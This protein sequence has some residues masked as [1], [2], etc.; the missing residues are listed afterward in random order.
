M[1]LSVPVSVRPWVTYASAFVAL[2]SASYYATTWFWHKKIHSVKKRAN[3]QL[4]LP[5]STPL[6]I[7]ISKE[8]KYRIRDVVLPYIDQIK[9]GSIHHPAVVDYITEKDV[10]KYL[11]EPNETFC[12]TEHAQAL[13]KNP[14][15]ESLFRKMVFDDKNS[16]LANHHLFLNHCPYPDILQHFNEIMSWIIDW[17]LLAT[18]NNEG[19]IKLIEMNLDKLDDWSNLSANP[20]AIDILK[21]NQ[22]KINWFTICFNKS[23]GDLLLQNQKMIPESFTCWKIISKHQSNLNLLK[24]NLDWVNWI[25]LSLN[26]SAIPL[27][28]EY[29]DKIKWKH[30]SSL[31]EAIHLIKNNLDKINWS[32]LSSNSAA[33]ELLKQHPD[34]IDWDNFCLNESKIAVEM[35]MENPD[36]IN[37]KTIVL[38]KS[39]PVEFLSQHIDKVWRFLN[40]GILQNPNLAN[41]IFVPNEQV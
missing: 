2:A 19:I 40:F 4:P 3:I 9:I 23:A 10:V 26:P 6:P 22:D 37:W 36:K 12:S 32:M 25:E 21:N 7:P 11:K 27:L 17:S 41:L 1:N 35:L 14:Y 13:I 39:V 29:P 18:S 30:L 16:Y 34:K 24:Q 20:L 8:K 33:G 38:N 31:P 5:H 28:K 15:L